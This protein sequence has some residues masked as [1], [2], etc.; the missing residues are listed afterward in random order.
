MSDRPDPPRPPTG[1]DERPTVVDRAVGSGYVWSMTA[2]FA[3]GPILA[4]AVMFWSYSD[5]GGEYPMKALAF[6]ALG[7]SSLL[8]MPPLLRLSRTRGRT[9]RHARIEVGVDRIRMTTAMGVNLE[10]RRVDG[11][12]VSVGDGGRRRQLHVGRSTAP[13]SGYDVEAVRAACLRHGWTWRDEATGTTS[14]FGPAAPAAVSPSA[15]PEIEL[16]LNQGRPDGGQHIGEFQRELRVWAFACLGVGLVVSLWLRTAYDV[17]AFWLLFP[18]LAP[19]AAAMAWVSRRHIRGSKVVLVISRAR[20]SV[21][22]GDS[23]D[24]VDRDNI[25]TVRAGKLYMSFRNH[26]GGQV[27]IMWYHGRRAEVLA[28]MTACG[29][30][31]DAK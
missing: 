16:T 21:R 31:V 28:Q 25:R 15:E 26:A 13:L 30:P 11:D 1:F 14:S 12:V 24:A 22:I 9:G 4:G 3:S 23:D 20:I 7:L 2:I 8:W 5:Y 6:I 19:A 10:W 27:M 18:A 17:S 29:W